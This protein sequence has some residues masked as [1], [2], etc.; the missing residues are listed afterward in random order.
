MIVVFRFSNTHVISILVVLYFPARR[1]GRRRHMP[2]R[3]T[4]WP[5][6]AS[7]HNFTVLDNISCQLSTGSLLDSLSANFDYGLQI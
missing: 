7:V 2:N 1:V 6:F 5:S 4:P 3:M